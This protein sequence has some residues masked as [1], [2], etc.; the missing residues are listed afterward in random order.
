MG[1]CGKGEEDIIAYKVGKDGSC[2]ELS[3]IEFDGRFAKYSNDGKLFLEIDFKE[4][5]K[6]CENPKNAN[7]LRNY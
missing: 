1:N 5:K 6:K 2:S 4:S 3:T 7:E